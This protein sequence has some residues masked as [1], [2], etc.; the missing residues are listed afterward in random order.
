M[1]DISKYTNDVK[2]RKWCQEIPELEFP[3]G[4]K[5]K[6]IPPFGGAAVRFIA[7]GISIYLDIDDSLGC[8]GSP[9]WE[10]YPYLGNPT[11][12]AME[13]TEELIIKIIEASEH[14]IFIKKYKIDL[15]YEDEQDFREYLKWVSSGKPEGEGLTSPNR[16]IRIASKQ[17]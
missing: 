10:I 3:E 13:D 15:D 5:V 17:P 1:V 7:N 6:I 16:L 11:R 8:F 4:M 2:Y 9:Y 12:V 14:K